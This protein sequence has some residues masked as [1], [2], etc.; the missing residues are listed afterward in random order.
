MKKIFYA[1]VAIATFVVLSCNQ[2][3]QTPV[4]EVDSTTI[5]S[6]VVD[7]TIVDSSIVET[8]V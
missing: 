2:P 1:I 3:I 6:T 7:T 5:D 8:G 4:N